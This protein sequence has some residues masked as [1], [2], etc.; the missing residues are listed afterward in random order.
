M[1]QEIIDKANELNATFEGRLADI[2]GKT[3]GPQPTMVAYRSVI[4]LYETALVWSRGERTFEA[5]LEMIK[6]YMLDPTVLELDEEG[7][8]KDIADEYFALD[9]LPFFHKHVG[10][11]ERD[12][13]TISIKIKMLRDSL[14]YLENGG[15][16]PKPKPKS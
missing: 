14:E 5:W 13:E 1:S 12:V 15:E 11:E 4:K 6:G 9:L 2:I 7:R 10:F 8:L 3:D 16:V